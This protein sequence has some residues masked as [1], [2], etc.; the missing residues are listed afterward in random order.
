MAV[1]VVRGRV[2]IH[3]QQEKNFSTKHLSRRELALISLFNTIS[4][5]LRA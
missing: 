4:L 2:N 1:M 5:F 3:R